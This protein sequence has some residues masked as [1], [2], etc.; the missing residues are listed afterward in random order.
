MWS[1]HGRYIY[2]I[3]LNILIEGFMPH[4][5]TKYPKPLG[6]PINMGKTAQNT[7]PVAPK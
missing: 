1:V 6:M 5:P 3:C 4:E 2:F 7:G